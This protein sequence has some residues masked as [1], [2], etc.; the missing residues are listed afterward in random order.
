MANWDN[1]STQIEQERLRDA[2]DEGLVEGYET[3]L[4]PLP[5]VAYKRLMDLTARERGYVYGWLVKMD[6]Q[7]GGR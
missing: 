5:A 2:F 1:L 6:E 3:P 4:N 7:L